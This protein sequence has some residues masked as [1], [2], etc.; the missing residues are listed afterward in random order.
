MRRLGEPPPALAKVRPE[1]PE[2]LRDVIEGMLASDPAQRFQSA[3]D[4]VRALN[5]LAPASG[6]Y[7]TAEIMLRGRKR[8]RARSLM[9]ALGGLAVAG[10]VVAGILVYNRKPD[11]V[12]APV[13]P[14]MVVIAGGTYTIGSNTGSPLSRPEH[15][16]RVEAFGIDVREVSVGE[17]AAYVATGRVTAPW[18]TE[19]DSLLP[20]TGVSYSEAMSFCAW[21]HPPDGRLPKEEEWEAA[22]R[23]LAGNSFPWGNAWDPSAANT[24]SAQRSAPAPV[25][26]FPQGKTKEGV[27]DLVGNVWE[28]TMSPMAPYQGGPPMPS[29][30]VGK[31]YVIRGGAFNTPDSTAFTTLRGYADPA[32]PRATLDKTGFRCVMPVRAPTPRR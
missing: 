27:H 11:V 17:Y 2:L 22:A 7:A 13:D 12:V 31:Y 21:R 9:I 15:K 20:V 23:G 5:G 16:L 8:K 19:P 3:G 18:T 14:D 6:G 10:I 4:V 32:A 30:T 28:W 1:A 25:G 26:S 24:Q 29:G